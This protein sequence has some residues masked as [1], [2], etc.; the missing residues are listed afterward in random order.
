MRPH[1]T[2]WLTSL[3]PRKANQ[4]SS[5]PAEAPNEIG[6]GREWVG[7][8]PDLRD[9]GSVQVVGTQLWEKPVDK[10][11]RDGNKKADDVSPCDPLITLS[12]CEELMGKATPCD[13]L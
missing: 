12:G 9:D 1:S 6:Y 3:S 13:G 10:P 4:R 8:I 5:Y 11:E 7:T 2:K